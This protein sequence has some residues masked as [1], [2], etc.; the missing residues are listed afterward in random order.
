MSACDGGV[1]A[2]GLVLVTHPHQHN[3]VKR[4]GGVIEELG[5]DGFHA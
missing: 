2:D 1:A 3:D 5:H 4:R